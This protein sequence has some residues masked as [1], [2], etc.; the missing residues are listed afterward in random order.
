ME[1]EEAQGRD[2]KSEPGL[3]VKRMSA[4]M[5]RAISFVHKSTR[6][7]QKYPVILRTFCPYREFEK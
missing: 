6:S 1:K 4:A 3:G 2:T 5:G 7:V